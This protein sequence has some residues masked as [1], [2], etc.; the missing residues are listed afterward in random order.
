SGAGGADSGKD[1][2][3]G[4][5]HGGWIGRDLDAGAG[6]LDGAPDRA[7]V[8]GAVVDDRD[9]NAHARTPFVDGMDV[10]SPVWRV[11]AC[12]AKA[13][14][15]KIASA[16]WCALRA[17]IRSM[18]AVNPALTAKARQNSSTRL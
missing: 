6:C 10:G 5:D 11:A 8:P 15:L 14:A 4:A 9:G 2:G 7:Q 16:A 13:P 1:D 12:R 3:I 18:C 17:R